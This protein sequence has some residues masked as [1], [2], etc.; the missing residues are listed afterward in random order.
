MSFRVNARNM[1]T[2]RFLKIS[3]VVEMTKS[4]NDKIRFFGNAP[5]VQMDKYLPLCWNF[6]SGIGLF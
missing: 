3:P 5:I 2:L 6:S 1:G 4:G